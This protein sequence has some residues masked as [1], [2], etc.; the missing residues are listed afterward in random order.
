MVSAWPRAPSAIDAQSAL[1][2]VMNATVPRPPRLVPMTI[3]SSAIM[4]VAS[5]IPG[6]AMETMIVGTE[7]MKLPL[8]AVR[9]GVG[10]GG[11]GGEC[12]LMLKRRGVGRERVLM[13]RG[14]YE[15]RESVR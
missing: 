7:V 2:A 9:R 4:D 13:R 11:G 15:E 10:G 6:C 1:I 8:I 3:S 14:F 12:V 5:S